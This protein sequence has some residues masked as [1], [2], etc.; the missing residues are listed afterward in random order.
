M[1]RHLETNNNKRTFSYETIDQIPADLSQYDQPLVAKKPPP[2]TPLY[3]YAKA[4]SEKIHLLRE[5]RESE[6]LYAM[7][8][9]AI[10][11]EE[12]FSLPFVIVIESDMLDD[13]GVLFSPYL[14]YEE[15]TEPFYMNTVKDERGMTALNV[16]LIEEIVYSE[17]RIIE[18]LYKNARNEITLS[19]EDVFRVSCI[20][21]DLSSGDLTECDV[22]FLCTV[23]I[24]SVRKSITAFMQHLYTSYSNILEGLTEETLSQMKN[25]FLSNTKDA[26][27]VANKN[28]FDSVQKFTELI[29]EYCS[30][31]ESFM[32]QE[33]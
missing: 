29:R 7:K 33:K 22:C 32:A 1:E 14:V 28:S 24:G 26:K 6:I 30:S 10:K 31:I 12:Y 4:V 16:S 11:S 27:Y 3:Y 2:Q 19:D 18:A 5:G 25:K 17:R 15:P 21:Y 13:G 9:K 20:H 23:A 8:S